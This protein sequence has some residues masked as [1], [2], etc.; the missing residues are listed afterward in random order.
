LRPLLKKRKLK[1]VREP[2]V[3]MVEPTAPVVEAA[4]MAGFLA[5]RW[6]KAA[7]PSVPRLAEV[8]AFIANELVLAIPVNAAKPIKK[9]PLRAPEGPIPS[10][11][12]H[13]LGSNI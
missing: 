4:N 7:L 2:K 6:K 11:L 3:S 1:K 10:L 13:P 12:D 8:E 9:E 5:A